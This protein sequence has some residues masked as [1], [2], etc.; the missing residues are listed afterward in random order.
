MKFLLRFLLLALPLALALPVAPVRAATTPCCGPITSDGDRL[1]AMLD[2]SGV[3][4]LWLAHEHVNWLTGAPDPA[5]PGYARHATHCS[6]FA[7]AMAERAGVY[8]LR[9]PAHSQALL[10]TAQ[11]HWLERDGGANGW[12]M[13]DPRTAQT[14]ANQGWFVVAVFGNPDPHR[15]GHIAVLRPGRESLARFDR[16]GP[17]ETQAGGHNFIRTTIARGFS[18]HPGAW[19]P[20]GTGTIRFFAHPVNWS[21]LAPPA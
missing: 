2:R 19:E 18:F 3:G 17:E 16:L 15:P 1:A 8:L 9:P 10:A 4:H 7:A 5:R 21:S 14:L 6:A 11:M 13:V 20:G 12:R